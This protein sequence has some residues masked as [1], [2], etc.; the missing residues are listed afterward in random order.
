MSRRQK[1]T[2][3]PSTDSLVHLLVTI[4][5]AAPST[6]RLQE[7]AGEG[8]A[9]LARY[10]AWV[11]TRK[12]QATDRELVAMEFLEGRCTDDARTAWSHYTSVRTPEA[13]SQAESALASAATRLRAARTTDTIDPT[14]LNI[15]DDLLD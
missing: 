6:L 11:L 4:A 5:E 12:G 7:L 8:I 10:N 1:P 2:W 14:D 15:P 9:E 13:R 3:S